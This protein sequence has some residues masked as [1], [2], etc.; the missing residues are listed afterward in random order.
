VSPLEEGLEIEIKEIRD[1][2]SCIRHSPVSPEG[3]NMSGMGQVM[4]MLSGPN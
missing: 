3:M 1:V 2:Q 4:F